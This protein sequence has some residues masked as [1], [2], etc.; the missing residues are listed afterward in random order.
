[1]TIRWHEFFTLIDSPLPHPKCPFNISNVESDN[2]RL[3]TGLLVRGDLEK[4][5]LP[6]LPPHL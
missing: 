3:F 5:F 2:L 6:L 1:M 4:L